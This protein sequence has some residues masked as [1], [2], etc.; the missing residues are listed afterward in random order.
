MK[1]FTCLYIFTV[2]KRAKIDVK[3][4]SSCIISLNIIMYFYVG[5]FL[6]F[7]RATLNL[8]WYSDILIIK[9]AY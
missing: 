9:N 5:F 3:Y 2:A 1:L 8:F 7:N 6:L 4:C